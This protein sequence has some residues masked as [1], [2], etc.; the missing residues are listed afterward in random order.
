[1]GVSIPQA[2]DLFEYSLSHPQYGTLIVEEPIGWQNDLVNIKRSE[3]NFS[4]VTVYNLNLEFILN[5]A[6]YLRNVYKEF[7]LQAQVKLIKRVVH[8]TEQE[9]VI[10]YQSILDGYSY[11]RSGQKVKVNTLESE[12]VSQIKGYGNEQVEIS[13]TDSISG[14]DI[15]KTPEVN[16]VIDGK[17]ILR[18]T[19]WNQ[20]NDTQKQELGGSND[21]ES[22]ALLMDEVANS[23]TQAFPQTTQKITDGGYGFPGDGVTGNMFYAI[24]KEDI[25]VSLD[26][27]M[28]RTLVTAHYN[29]SDNIVLNGLKYVSANLYLFRFEDESDLGRDQYEYKGQILLASLEVDPDLDGNTYKVLKYDRRISSF[30]IKKGE[31]WCLGIRSA[32]YGNSY[33]VN[34]DWSEFG[35]SMEM[36]QDSFFEASTV[37][38][39]QPFE[40]FDKLLRI[41]TGNTGLQLVSNYFGRT[42]L[43]YDEDGEGAYM[44]IANGF[45]AR[46][47]KDKPITTSWADA[48]QSYSA[49]RNISYGI[50]TRGLQEFVRIEPL[51][52][53]F[54]EGT[55]R[56]DRVVN[57]NDIKISVENQYSYSGIEIG[58]AK[59]GDEY[60]EAVGLDEPNGKG[61]WT[62]P[63]SRA[64]GNYSKVS[65]YRLDMT[66]FEFARRKP[67]YDYGT[68]DTDY[69]SDVFVLDLKPDPSSS[70]YLQRKWQDDFSEE[71]R[72]IYSPETATNLRFSPRQLFKQHEWFIKNCLVSYPTLEVKYGSIIGNDTLSL[73]GEGTK[74]PFL[75]GEMARHQFQNLTIEW[76]YDTDYELEQKI[77]DNI[78]GIFEITDER[79]LTYRIRLFDFKDGKYKGLIINGIQ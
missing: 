33:D 61:T 29:F 66:G 62:T 52:Y 12:I 26:I 22:M 30:P 58:A 11:E 6:D 44:C 5:G 28:P 63:L 27:K 31:S 37:K 60:K 32:S 18:V 75:I 56:F 54:Q 7:G 41:M 34:Y 77:L 53:F 70:S 39:T 47:F 21:L 38:V 45:K 23:D 64:E 74:D 57:S 76:K 35:F 2:Y 1:M 16:T 43:G 4:V 46:G 10:Q 20:Q 48:L 3:K 19:K 73:D 55:L 50:E 72:G 14:V 51:E 9:I 15:G 65:K 40:L 25:V 67:E 79:G 36:T 24:A 49:I 69:D 68:E 59:G 17:Q 8:P 42:D 71:P 13:R 78:Y